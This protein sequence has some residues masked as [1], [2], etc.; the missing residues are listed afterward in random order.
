MRKRLKRAASEARNVGQ[1][2]SDVEQQAGTHPMSPEF[3]NSFPVLDVRYFPN[4]ILGSCTQMLH[5]DIGLPF[6]ISSS[7]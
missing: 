4:T 2:Q 5:D 1:C 3:L 6:T 7:A